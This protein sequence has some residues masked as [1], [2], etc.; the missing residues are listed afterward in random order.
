[1]E[2]RLNADLLSLNRYPEGPGGHPRGK[3]YIPPVL[4]EGLLGGEGDRAWRP[5]W[6]SL[7]LARTQHLSF[8]DKLGSWSFAED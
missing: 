2:Q 8:R 3:A 1:M 7:L 6:R 5:S 4:E